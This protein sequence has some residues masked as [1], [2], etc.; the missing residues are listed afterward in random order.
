[1]LY[2]A[3]NLDI[4]YGIH[5]RQTGDTAEVAK[6]TCWQM[7]INVATDNVRSPG[8]EKRLEE[9]EYALKLFKWN[10]LGMCE[11]RKQGEKCDTLLSLNL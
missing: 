1:M 3:K 7:I 4:I 2:K 10:V 8:S 9:L 6:N 5:K 11:A